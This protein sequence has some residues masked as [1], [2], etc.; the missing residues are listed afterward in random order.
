M[1]APAILRLFWKYY[2]GI[3]KFY[4][5]DWTF[6]VD[7]LEYAVYKDNEIPRIVNILINKF[8]NNDTVFETFNKKMRSAEDILKDY[9][10]S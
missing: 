4:E 5:E 10:I 9:G 6:F 8:F 1:G 7:C 3:E 2:G